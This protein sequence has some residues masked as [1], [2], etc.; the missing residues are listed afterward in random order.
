LAVIEG[1]ISGGEL[2]ISKECTVFTSIEG[3]ISH[4]TTGA[5]VHKDTLQT[6]QK[7]VDYCRNWNKKTAPNI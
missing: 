2:L 1:Q 6:G 3:Q 5:V 4:E 7:F